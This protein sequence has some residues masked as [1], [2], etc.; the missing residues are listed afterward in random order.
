MW[1][2]V[3]AWPID[4]DRGLAGDVRHQEVHGDVLT[5]DIL[6]HYVADGLGHH[7]RV[8]VRIVLQQRQHA[9]EDQCSLGHITFE[10]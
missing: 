7:V 10:T 3:H 4:L 5:V 8:Q 2:C 9:A 1:V 6:I